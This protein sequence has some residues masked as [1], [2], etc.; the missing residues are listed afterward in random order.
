M[1]QLPHGDDEP[2]GAGRLAWEMLDTD[3][4]VELLGSKVDAL[5][6]D[7]RLLRLDVQGNTKAIHALDVSVGQVTAEL[8]GI[9][10]TLK[11][12]SNQVGELV[13]KATESAAQDA[14]ARGRFDSYTTEHA[15]EI[16]AVRKDINLLNATDAELRVAVKAARRR[17]NIKWGVTLGI[18]SAA[19]AFVWEIAKYAIA[20]G[21]LH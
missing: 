10:K 6:T 20:H 17:A 19:S 9:G 13:Q 16:A 18:V 14:F 15:V 1:S 8:G 4:R 12:L 21:L 5:V 7:Q 2:N 3:G 11:T